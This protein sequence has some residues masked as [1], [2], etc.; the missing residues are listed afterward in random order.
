MTIKNEMFEGAIYYDN[1]D[2]LYLD[3]LPD[4]YFEDKFGDVFIKC[5]DGCLFSNEIKRIITKNVL[6]MHKDGVYLVKH[7]NHVDG[8]VER[9]IIIK[10]GIVHVKETKFNQE[11]FFSTNIISRKI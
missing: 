8:E 1:F 2:K 10:N 4:G 5:E 7:I 6:K 11:S 3:S 9:E